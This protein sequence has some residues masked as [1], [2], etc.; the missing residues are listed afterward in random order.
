[1]EPFEQLR[2][3]MRSMDGFVVAGHTNPDG[4]AIGSCL[5]MA[6]A[7]KGL[8]KRVGVALEPY[9]EKYSII[10][11]AELLLADLDAADPSVVMALDCGSPD[12]LGDAEP[13]LKKAKAVACV[14]HHAA[15]KEFA[16]DCSIIDPG[17][18]STCELVYKVLAPMGIVD[19]NIATALYAGILTDT[20]GFRHGGASPETMII[21]SRLLEQG[22]PS[23]EIYNELLIRR[24]LAEARLMGLAL[25]RFEL[26]CSGKVAA[27]KI[28]LEDMAQVGAIARD[29][30]GIAGLLLSIRGVEACALVYEK[31][32]GN[33]KTSFRS[34]GLDVGKI[35]ESL[36]GG[37][38]RQAAGGNVAGSL[39][40]AYA[41]ATGLLVEEHARAR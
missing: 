39:D 36:G 21:V 24:S 2:E 3:M 17:A 5:A 19:K 18:S 32:P 12:R 40:D 37:G 29:T 25:S 15:R 26:L 11:G 34:T 28:S 38:H 31:E 6:L 8:G 33:V 13:L 20:G 23:F 14:D 4:D 30:G 9:S 10:P 35:A 22:I 27:C 16:A 1:M 7:L 41:M